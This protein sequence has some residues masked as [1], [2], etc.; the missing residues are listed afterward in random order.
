[1]IRARFIQHTVTALYERGPFGAPADSFVPNTNELRYQ[2]TLGEIWSASNEL[3]YVKLRY[4][5]LD[6][7]T[8]KPMTRAVADDATSASSDFAFAS[9]VAELGL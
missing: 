2:K 9:A 8:S 3:V 7:A 5:E 1:M 4:K 6:G